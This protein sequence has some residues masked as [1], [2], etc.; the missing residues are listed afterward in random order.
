MS[1]AETTR[2]TGT[3]AAAGVARRP[4][5]LLFT[6]AGWALL[7]LVLLAVVLVAEPSRVG[8]TAEL[9]SLLPPSLLGLVAGLANLAVLLLAGVAVAER[10]IHRDVRHVVRVL[11]A[12]GLGYGAAVTL[13]TVLAA[14]LGE[15]RP[16]VLS[17]STAGG[18]ASNPLHAY[19]AAA[20]AYL[21]ATRPVH[22][23]SVTGLMAA[24][25][26]VTAAAVLLSGYTTALALVLTLLVGAVCA[27][28]VNYTVGVSIPPPDVG[29]LVRE[30]DRLGLEPLCLDPVGEDHEGNRRFVAET[31]DRRLEVTLLGPDPAGGVFRRLLARIVLRDAAAPPLLL[32]L[33]DRVEHTALLEYAAAAAGTAAPRLLAVGDL[34]PSTAFLVREYVAVR[35][36]TELADA[37]LDDD[38]LDEVWTQLRLLHSRRVA[39]RAI[40]PEAVCRRTDGRAVLTGLS[41]GSVA[42][43][44]WALSLDNA[45]LLTTLALRVGP[46]RAVDSAVRSLG[47]DTVAAVLPFL[48]SI[49]LPPAL[50]RA[51]RFRRDLLGR[52]REEISRSAPHAPAQ[53]VQLERMP[54]RTVATVVVATAVGLALAYQLPG[55]DW[56]TISDP[57]PLWTGTAVV[58]SLLS[59]LA[60]ALALLGFS[61]VRLRLWRTVLVQYAS[62]FVRIATPA[63]VGSLALNTR[64]LVREGAGTAQAVSAVGVSQLAGLA[65]LVP[66]L[67]LCAYLSHTGYPGDFSPSFTLLA[68]VGVLSAL[69]AALLAVPRLRRAALDRLRPHLSGVLPQLLDLVQQPRRLALG[70]GGTLL[71]TVSLV[72]CLHVSILAFGATP[73]LAAVGVVYLA[74]NAIGSAAPSPG[75]LGA[76]EAAL[77]GGLTT[78]AGVPAAAALSGVLLFR[79]LTFW[80]PVLPGWLAFARLQRRRAI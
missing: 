20:V 54:P 62:C 46:R 47:T 32:G 15:A 30:L 71:L 36:L 28:L 66:L 55:V 18:T 56:T 80:L 19:L 78:I 45:A 7:A 29:R 59:V 13:N 69:A 40:G 3:D 6:A 60:P 35:P 5:D 16:D 11:F 79:L 38:F 74:G 44:S 75:G 4:V 64:Y 58:L 1:T 43:G 27:S 22:L 31:V 10:L 57:D 52:L 14:L 53:P 61:P 76:V 68:V 24:G 50:R 8:D 63:G 51:V 73:S 49:G 41:T 48:Q 21:H 65:T 37:D 26:A 23:V 77:I 2:R 39:H 12:A 70:F 72:L 34:D 42:A 9:R 17:T 33:R 25:V 67:V